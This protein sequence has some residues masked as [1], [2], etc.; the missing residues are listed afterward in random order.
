MR[1]IASSPDQN[2]FQAQFSPGDERLIC[3]QAVTRATGRPM[4]STITSRPPRAV[5]G[6]QLPTASSG[7][8]SRA[9]R[10]TA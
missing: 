3:F 10:P 8:T 5:R 2:L 9:G 7:T 1:V 6:S 4:T